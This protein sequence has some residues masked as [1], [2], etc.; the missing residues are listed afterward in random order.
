MYA[1]TVLRKLNC[2]YVEINIY[3]KTKSQLDKPILPYIIRINKFYTELYFRFHLD[4]D[5]EI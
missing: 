3:Y 5:Y 4:A 2:K 1:Y